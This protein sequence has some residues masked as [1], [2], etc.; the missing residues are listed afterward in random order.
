M[1]VGHP[2]TSR[3][4]TGQVWSQWGC[5]LGPRKRMKCFFGYSRWT[6]AG[7]KHL[8][9]AFTTAPNTTYWISP[10]LS[11]SLF[12]P[13]T[14]RLFIFTTWPIYKTASWWVLLQKQGPSLS[15]SSRSLAERLSLQLSAA[16]HPTAALHLKPGWHTFYHIHTSFVMWPAHYALSPAILPGNSLLCKHKYLKSNTIVVK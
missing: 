14:V 11:P 10:T 1:S 7:E 12:W 15:S 6:P 8:S 13:Q 5:Y 4:V 2:R 16:Q 9:S 3:Q